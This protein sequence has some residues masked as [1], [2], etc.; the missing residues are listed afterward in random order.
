MYMIASITQEHVNAI[1]IFLLFWA[2]FSSL[3]CHLLK[4][5]SMKVLC[6]DLETPVAFVVAVRIEFVVQGAILCQGFIKRK[7]QH[8]TLYY[9]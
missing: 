6:K 3:I 1:E 9:R 5:V 8:S 4:M 7:E 2:A